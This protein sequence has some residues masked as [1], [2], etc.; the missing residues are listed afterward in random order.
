MRMQFSKQKN[1][2]ILFVAILIAVIA[3]GY[4]FALESHSFAFKIIHT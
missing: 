3:I 2:L 4:Y 1:R